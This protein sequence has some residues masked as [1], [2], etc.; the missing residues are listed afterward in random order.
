MQNSAITPKCVILDG[1]TIYKTPFVEEDK[2]N[3]ISAAKDSI[4]SVKA[5][6][7]KSAEAQGELHPLFVQNIDNCVQ[8]YFTRLD[9]LSKL[10]AS[11]N[12]KVIQFGVLKN[13]EKF[14]S[15]ILKIFTKQ[16]LS[17]L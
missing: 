10:T 8:K 17:K 5:S 2:N 9:S 12:S 16:H 4:M 3:C 1:K 13:I 15:D 7:L 14:K 6:Y 11:D